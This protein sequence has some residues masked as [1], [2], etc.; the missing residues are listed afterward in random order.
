MRPRHERNI[1]LHRFNRRVVVHDAMALRV[2]EA[3]AM[4]K[5]HRFQISRVRVAE[6]NH[7]PLAGNGDF[8][9]RRDKFVPRFQVVGIDSSG[10]ENLPIIG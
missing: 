5:K 7:V 10:L 1:K 4:L 9:P 3:A 6:F 8:M 2:E